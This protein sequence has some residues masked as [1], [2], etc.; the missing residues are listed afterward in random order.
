MLNY[1]RST[2]FYGPVVQFGGFVIPLICTKAGLQ[3]LII[4]SSTLQM[5]NSM[6]S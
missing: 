5:S 6:R 3:I 1:L 2:G 4:C